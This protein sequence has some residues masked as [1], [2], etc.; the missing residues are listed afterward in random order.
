MPSQEIIILSKPDFAL[1][2][3]HL[4]ALKVRGGT[5]DRGWVR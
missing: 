5:K 2:Y 4:T 1:S 3:Y